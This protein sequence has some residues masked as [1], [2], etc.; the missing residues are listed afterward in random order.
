[1]PST[2]GLGGSGTLTSQESTIFDSSVDVIATGVQAGAAVYSVQNGTGNA[3]IRNPALNGASNYIPLG[4]GAKQ[5]FIINRAGGIG[6]LFGKSDAGGTII[7]GGPTG[8]T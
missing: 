1:M 3:Y 5:D 6:Q 8:G 7:T 4:P 2:L